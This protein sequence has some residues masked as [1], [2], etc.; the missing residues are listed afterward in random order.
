[1]RAL[2]RQLVKVIPF[3]GWAASSAIAFTGTLVMGRATIIYFER[4]KRQPDEDDVEKI[5]QQAEEDARRYQRE[6]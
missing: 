5:K 3:G 4:G 1:M 6:Q 2:A